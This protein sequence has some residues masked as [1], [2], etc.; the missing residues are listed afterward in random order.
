MM[1]G[2]AGPV[3]LASSG[4]TFLTSLQSSSMYVLY[5]FVVHPSM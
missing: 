5:P 4:K 2:L 3:N 1:S